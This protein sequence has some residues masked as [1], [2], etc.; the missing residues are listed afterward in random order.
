M[1]EI[2]FFVGFDW[3]SKSHAACL[4]D[5]NGKV[6][7][8]RTIDHDGRSLSQFYDWLLAAASAAAEGIA[9]AIETSHGPLVEGMLERG[10]QV[11]AINPK[12]LDRFRDRFSVAGAKDDRRDA[13]VLGSSL[14][15]D[16]HAFRRVAVDDP[17]VIELRE[18][19]RMHDELGQERIRL[20]NRM[21]EQLWRYYPQALKLTD[22]PGEEWF[23]ALWSLL[24]EP[25]R[26]AKFRK[27]AIQRIL[28]THRIRRIDADEVLAILR[29]KPLAVAKGAV[30]AATAHIAALIERLRL[31]NAQIKACE[32]KLQ[33]LT[34]ELEKE[35]EPEPGQSEQRDVAIL[36][37][38]PG[39]GRI[40]LATLLAEANQ[41]LANRD[42]QALRAL[43]GV[44][45]VTRQSGKGRVIVRRLACNGRL[46]NALF[47][48][49]RAAIQHDPTSRRRYDELRNRGHGHA[50]ALR[51][52]GDRLLFVACK[53]LEHQTAF[54]P[55]R[56][57]QTA[58]K[59]QPLPAPS[60]GRNT[61]QPAKRKRALLES[62]PPRN[63]RRKLIDEYRAGRLPAPAPSHLTQ[64]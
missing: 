27:S 9:V 39:L 26:A 60:P 48:W 52:V 50:R 12:Q 54:Q 30:K 38:C 29:E 20:A 55:D 32:K 11:F 53:M 34:R 17:I 51:S 45:P 4:L 33:E 36:R 62:N 47:H 59:A 15:T 42:Y 40:N 19:S 7:G 8:E 24:P 14:R 6:I 46:R 23:M 13:L 37:S 1:K 58:P 41:P 28:G 57:L 5:R 2:E 3:A 16:A 61:T 35:Q 22:D 64:R 25:S 43:A 31:V 44:A 56:A 18:W 10:F 63:S 49:S 21:R